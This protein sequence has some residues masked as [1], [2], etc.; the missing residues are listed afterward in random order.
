[1]LG[2]RI[3]NRMSFVIVV[4][5]VLMCVGCANSNNKFEL[6]GLGSLHPYYYPQ[7]NYEGEFHAIKEAYKKEFK[8]I[9][10][11]DKSGIVKI[12]FHVNCKGQTGNFLME[13]YN[14]NY[15]PN[16][17][18]SEITGQLLAITKGLDGWIAAVNDDGETVNSHKFLSF[19]IK[20]GAIVN[21]LPK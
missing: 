12:R 15:Q 7:L 10:G 8:E 11:D 20:D 5:V 6:C 18:N 16:H 3:R 4:C 19:R 9:S 13:T 17:I 21:I 14:L 1:M 2:L